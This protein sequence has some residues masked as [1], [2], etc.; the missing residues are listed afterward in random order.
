MN[1]TTVYFEN[2][3][4]PN[5]FVRILDVYEYSA[6]KHMPNSN[7][8]IFKFDKPNRDYFSSI[9]ESQW[10]HE[11]EYMKFPNWYTSNLY[12]LDRWVEILSQVKEDTIITDCDIFFTGDI[13]SVFDQDFDIAYT[14]RTDHDKLY[15]NVYKKPINGG[16][17]FFKPTQKSREFVKNWRD[18]NWRMALNSD[19]YYE[20]FEKYSGC[21]Q[22]AFGYLLENDKETNIKDFPC[23]IYNG[24]AIDLIKYKEKGLPKVVHIKRPIWQI[25]AS[26]YHIDKLPDIP[27]HDSFTIPEY[28]DIIQLWR[29]LEDEKNR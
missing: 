3:E 8:K 11:N 22:T 1:I 2:D 14:K 20:W 21:N 27:D 16:V 23:A 9:R 18:V 25:A 24:C 13:S 10:L 29:E 6:K 28:R 19:F 12:K 15:C 17:F 26:D 7:V 4:A 5:D